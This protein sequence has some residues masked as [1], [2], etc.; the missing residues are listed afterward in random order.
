MP[1]VSTPSTTPSSLAPFSGLE[2]DRLR[3]IPGESAVDR[4]K[5]IRKEKRN[6]V[7]APSAAA[8]GIVPLP[9]YL[10]GSLKRRGL[11]NKGNTCFINATLQCLFNC[12]P[13][14]DYI[15]MSAGPIRDFFWMAKALRDGSCRAAL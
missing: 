1:I 11:Q 10:I 12:T 7:D 15:S 5:R 2:Q 9:P 4:Q 3:A 14:L 6:S 13:L 8:L